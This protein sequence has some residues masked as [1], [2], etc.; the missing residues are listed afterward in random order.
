MS[1]RFYDYFLQGGCGRPGHRRRD[2]SAS[3]ANGYDIKQAGEERARGDEN[4]SSL[5]HLGDSE[6][7]AWLRR[8]RFLAAADGGD[9][10]NFV[11]ITRDRVGTDKFKVDAKARNIAPGS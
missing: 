9:Q 1:L 8:S 6:R 2:R 3:S 10:D 5:L 4:R 11:P 7:R